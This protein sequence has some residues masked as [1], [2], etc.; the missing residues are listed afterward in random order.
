MIWLCALATYTV[1]VLTP[2]LVVTI[3]LLYTGKRFLLQAGGVHV[4][5]SAANPSVIPVAVAVGSGTV[6]LT[7]TLPAEPLVVM[8]LPVPLVILLVLGVVVFTVVVCGVADTA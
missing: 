5:T 3:G 1:P 7:V 8:L 6:W 4:V 2:A